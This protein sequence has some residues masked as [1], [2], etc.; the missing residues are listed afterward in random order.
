MSTKSPA[1]QHPDLH[2]QNH[3]HSASQQ[4]QQPAINPPV[5]VFSAPLQAKEGQEPNKQTG[6]G[7]QFA[8]PVFKLVDALKPDYIISNPQ[9]VLELLKRFQLLERDAICEF[10]EQLARGN[11]ENEGKILVLRTEGVGGKEGN[12]V[13][14]VFYD[15]LG[16]RENL[17]P[18]RGA[19]DPVH[20]LPIEL[21]EAGL[22]STTSNNPKPTNSN[23]KIKKKS[24]KGGKVKI[25]NTHLK[26]LAAQYQDFDRGSLGRTII[27]STGRVARTIRYHS[28]QN[29]QQSFGSNHNESI[30][31]RLRMA[32]QKWSTS[33]IFLTSTLIGSIVKCQLYYLSSLKILKP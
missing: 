32:E 18:S 20:S 6:P 26:D 19:L 25:T 1:C 8:T 22:T 5:V 33:M 17:G 28:Q 23:R 30:Q 12:T 31:R 16:C 15:E 21:Q 14:T 27:D 10:K 29:H 3:H 24:G 9:E 13:K 2:H 11:L 7:K 4:P